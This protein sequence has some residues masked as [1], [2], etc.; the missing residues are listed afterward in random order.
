MARTEVA[1]NSLTYNN[2]TICT[3]TAIGVATGTD[4]YSIKSLGR[5][6]DLRIVVTNDGTVTGTMG[7]TLK[8]GG[9]D[10]LNSQGDLQC[11]VIGVGKVG[12]FVFD[13][14]RFRQTDAMIDVDSGVSGTLVAFE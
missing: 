8:A 7:L 12:V 14:A 5:G 2:S 13:N 1:V 9:Y 4:G 3:K 10:P 11:G 6:T